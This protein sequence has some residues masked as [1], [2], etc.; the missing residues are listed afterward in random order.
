MLSGFSYE[1]IVVDNASTDDT[2]AK[3][4]KV[5]GVAIVKNKTNLGFGR[6]NNIGAAIAK[7]EYL[8]FLNSDMELIDDKLIDMFKYLIKNP[9][10]GII[11]PKFLN[12]DLSPQGSV[13]PPQTLS[14]AFKEFWLGKE[15]TYSKYTP[16]G[17]KPL[18]V[19]S[20]SG[21]AMMIKKSILNKIGGWDKRYFMYFEDLELCRQ[22]R[23]LGL[24]I[25][26]YPDCKVVHRHGVSGQSLADSSNQWRRLIPS[27]KIYHG[28]IKHYL[29][30]LIARSGQKLSSNLN[31]TL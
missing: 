13:W 8:L 23:K 14:N 11:A 27:S 24:K 20:V 29:L 22:V 25:Y 6:A 9:D 18:E 15:H 21:G 2:V 31:S 19:F 30:F 26:Y 28:I 12:I 3:L 5:N 17:Y 1:I 10:I 7:G 16:Q 4:K